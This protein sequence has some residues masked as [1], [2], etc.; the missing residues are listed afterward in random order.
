M[1]NKNKNTVKTTVHETAQAKPRRAPAKVS[2][3]SLSKSDYSFLR[4]LL[5]QKVSLAIQAGAKELSVDLL[6]GQMD[7]KSLPLEGRYK[8]YQI[9]CYAGLVLKQ[10]VE[11]SVCKYQQAWYIKKSDPRGKAR[12][13]VLKN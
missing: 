6:I 9:K 3:N 1:S 8:P 11:T 4:G 10:L 13:Y 5:E 12:L 7:L 2:L